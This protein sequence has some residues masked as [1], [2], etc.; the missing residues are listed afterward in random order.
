M[1]NKPHQLPQM[2]PVYATPI[3]PPALQP[4]PATPVLQQ[5][6]GTIYYA[7]QI[8]NLRQLQR[9]EPNKGCFYFLAQTS[10]HASAGT[11]CACHKVD[12]TQLQTLLK[13]KLIRELHK[14]RA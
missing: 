1:P 6:Y 12:Q 9:L 7:P 14:G 8:G 3:Q 4:S 5:L 2:L 11:A 13:A 10:A